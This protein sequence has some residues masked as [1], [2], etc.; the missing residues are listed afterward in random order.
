MTAPDSLLQDV[1]EEVEPELEDGTARCRAHGK[2]LKAKLETA[3]RR[4]LWFLAVT[5][6]KMEPHYEA[7]PDSDGSF[8]D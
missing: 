5:G 1:S 4:P 2:V 6:K 8:S 3:R 7:V